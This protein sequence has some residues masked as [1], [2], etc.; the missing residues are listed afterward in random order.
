MWGLICKDFYICRKSFL[1][2][3]GV[4]LGLSIPYFIPIQLFSSEE[5]QLLLQAVFLIFALLI[6]LC[7]GEAQT[8]L[9]CGDQQKTWMYFVTASP[10]GVTGQV[11][12]KYYECILLSLFCT[13]WCIFLFTIQGAVSNITL[14]INL[15]SML[16]YIQLLVRALEFPFY[17]RFGSKY[18]NYYKLGVLTLFVMLFAIFEL[19]GN[20]KYLISFDLI[21]NFLKHLNTDA[22]TNLTLCIYGVFPWVSLF[23]L[24]LSYR[25]SL[26]L[27]QKGVDFLE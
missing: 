10:A 20:P 12:S 14:P 4:M 26:K 5:N 7:V 6:F 23:A 11:C 24:Y 27:F 3:L 21:I 25:V 9:F 19:Y 17:I 1:L 15:L 13:L 16:F 8:S 22:L 18:G 2:S